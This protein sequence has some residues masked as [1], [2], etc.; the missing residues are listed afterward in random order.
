M[1]RLASPGYQ[2]EVK[3]FYGHEFVM[4]SKVTFKDLT[5]TKVSEANTEAKVQAEFIVE[6]ETPS[7]TPNLAGMVTRSTVRQVFSLVKGESGWLI[8]GIDRQPL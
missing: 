8:D 1:L 5:I 4:Y 6:L 3:S 7:S 2:T